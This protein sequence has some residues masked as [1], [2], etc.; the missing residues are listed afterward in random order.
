M[1]RSLVLIANAAKARICEFSMDDGAEAP[2]LQKQ[3]T[4]LCPQRRG[5][6]T[7]EDG[8]GGGMDREG[9]AR[10]LSQVLRSSMRQK[11]FEELMLVASPA[12][13]GTLRRSLSTELAKRVVCS[14]PKD[15]TSIRLENLGTLLWPRPLPTQPEHPQGLAA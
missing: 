10:E 7:R 15:Y 5:R 3:M 4:V 2:K 6:A 9:F 1:K 13:L 14:I 12:F 11:R 8:R